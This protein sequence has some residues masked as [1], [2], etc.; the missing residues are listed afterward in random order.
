[1]SFVIVTDSAKQRIEEM[2]VENDIFAVTLG[3]KG[4]GCAGYQYDWGVADKEHSRS[5]VI[6]AGKGNLM[7][8][9]KSLL[10]LM[11]TEIDY[12]KDMFGA[13]FV[14]NNPKVKSSCGCGVS[15]SFDVSTTPQKES[16]FQPTW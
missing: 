4:G 13:Q 10:F 2:C 15:V 6:P 3:L 12:V 7:I 8:D 5:E 11:G 16:P 9:K 1:M 14:I